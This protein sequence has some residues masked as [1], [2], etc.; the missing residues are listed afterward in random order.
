MMASTISAH[1]STRPPP[2]KKAIITIQFL[3]ICASLSGQ[4]A[5]TPD[6]T[7]YIGGGFGKSQDYLKMSEK[8]KRAYAMGAMNGMLV[9]PFFDAPEKSTK[10]LNDYLKGVSNEQV[11]A[12]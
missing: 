12:I 2:M 10:W 6:K 11:A 5:P 3:L 9:A 4:P 7:V 1:V 8:E